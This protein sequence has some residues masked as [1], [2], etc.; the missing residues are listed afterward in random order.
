MK[1]TKIDKT[2]EKITDIESTSPVVENVPDTHKPI[3]VNGSINKE[4]LADLYKEGLKV[5]A[6]DCKRYMMLTLV[7]A[8]ME[9][10]REARVTIGNEYSPEVV[11]IT[12]EKLKSEGYGA[13]KVATRRDTFIISF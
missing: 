10:S 3:I 13:R 8:A 9:G 4:F 6:A 11:D 12:L 2:D 1:I 5:K 7:K